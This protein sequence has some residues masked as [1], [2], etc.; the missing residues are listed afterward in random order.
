MMWPKLVANKLFHKASGSNGFVAD[1]DYW[2]APPAASSSN[3]LLPSPPPEPSFHHQTDTT[4]LNY[5][6]F[7]STWN[8]GGMPPSANID[9]DDWLE[10]TEIYDIYV[11]GFQEIVPLSARNILGPERS[12]ISTKWT[13]LIR[14]TLNKS[15]S[16]ASLEGKDFQCIVSKQMVGLFVSVWVRGDRR[17]D[18]RHPSVSYV[19]C[20]LLGCLGNKGSVSLRFFLHET[21]LCFVCCH[22]ASGGKEGDEMHRNSDAMEIF[23][24]TSFPQGSSSNL[25]QKIL[26]HD[27]I[28]LLGDLNYRISLPEDTTRW[29][30]EQKKWNVLLE[31]DQLRCELV[32]G[33]AFE[34]W[35]EGKIRF[36]PTYKFYP[37]SDEYYGCIQGKKHN[38]KKAPAWCDRI[39]WHGKGV[40][41]RWYE[42]CDSK[43]SDH[44]PVR[45]IFTIEVEAPTSKLSCLLK[46]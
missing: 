44:R 35:N 9:L 31:K 8:V 2:E 42:R 7:V 4:G 10:T 22:L 25:P 16:A 11:L 1:F 18:F 33:R 27:R 43:L 21:S 46:M 36:S 28:I 39:L 38:K 24:R 6:L 23:S 37:N 13:S 19:G 40:K 14:S 17:R 3:A 29:L 32:E 45:A 20:G 12:S 26:D 34:G 30:V 5:K 41:Q 15:T